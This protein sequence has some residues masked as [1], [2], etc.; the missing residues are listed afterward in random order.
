MFKGKKKA[1]ISILSVFIAFV[2]VQS[3]FF[4]FSNA[5]ETQH[6]FGVLDLWAAEKFGF[7]GLFVAPGIFNA[8]VVGTIELISSILLMVGISTSRKILIPVGA[9]VA[10]SVITGAISFHLFTPL[11]VNVQGD[12]GT[13]FIMACGVWLSSV[14]LLMLHRDIVIKCIK[15]NKPSS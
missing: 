10:L 3:L 9:F 4:K 7:K 14:I 11:G 6:I 8:Y 15:G 5:P 1:L 2:F 12:G 13:L